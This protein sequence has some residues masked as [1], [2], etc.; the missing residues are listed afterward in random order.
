MELRSEIIFTSKM[1][2]QLT[3]SKRIKLEDWLL[4]CHLTK[5]KLFG[6]L[7]LKQVLTERNERACGLHRQRVLNDLL[8]S[9]NY[10]NKK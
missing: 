2:A 7:K 4:Y 6:G 3:P 1:N 10:Q 5:Y 8:K 9:T